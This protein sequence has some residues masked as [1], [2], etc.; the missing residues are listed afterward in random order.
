MVRWSGRSRDR[1]RPSGT[2]IVYSVIEGIAKLYVYL[3]MC[4]CVLYT[5]IDLWD[6]ESAVAAAAATAATTAVTAATAETNTVP[7]SET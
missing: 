3:C 4:V 6:F 1:G 5:Y 2:V 7:A